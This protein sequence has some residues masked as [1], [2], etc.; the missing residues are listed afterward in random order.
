MEETIQSKMLDNWQWCYSVLLF[1]DK[2]VFLISAMC[3]Y[4]HEQ[5]LARCLPWQHDLTTKYCTTSTTILIPEWRGNVHTKP[6]RQKNRQFLFPF[7]I[8]SP[9]LKPWVLLQ[10]YITIV[11]KS[12]LLLILQQVF[13]VWEQ[14][15]NIMQ[16]SLYIL[17]N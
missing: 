16:Y 11:T 1:M 7:I 6:L 9:V 12:M 2:V 3:I 14:K 17:K 13:N 10:N 4:L 15:Q 8:K 5:T